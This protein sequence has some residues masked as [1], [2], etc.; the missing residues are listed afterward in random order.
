MY[1]NLCTSAIYEIVTDWWNIKKP[2]LTRFIITAAFILFG[3]FSSIIYVSPSGIYLTVLV[4]EY[5]GVALLFI[6]LAE[7][8]I[9]VCGYGFRKFLA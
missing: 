1:I 3:F 5:T 6:C 9:I 7:I 2:L 4:D 8:I